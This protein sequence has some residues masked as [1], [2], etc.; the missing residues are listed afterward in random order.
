MTSGDAETDPLAIAEQFAA[1]LS[2]L[3]LFGMG[4]AEQDLAVMGAD[5]SRCD[6]LEDRVAGLDDAGGHDDDPD[7]GFEV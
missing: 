6:V 3:P 4:E 5:G 1:V 7:D 2:S